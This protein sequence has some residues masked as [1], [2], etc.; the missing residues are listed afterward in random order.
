MKSIKSRVLEELQNGAATKDQL[1][2]KL[3]LSNPKQL[4][5]AFQLLKAD[6]PIK[7][8]GNQYSLIKKDVVVSSVNK[9]IESNERFVNELRTSRINPTHIDDMLDLLF[10]ATFYKGAF[11]AHLQA[12]RLTSKVR[13]A[14]CDHQL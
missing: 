13:D 7:K 10:K 9:S 8:N 5:N 4:F 12:S 3:G 14:L 1:M 6:F 2:K 11:E